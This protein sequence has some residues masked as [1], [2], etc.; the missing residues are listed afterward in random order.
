MLFRRPMKIRI[1][2]FILLSCL[3]LF[4]F[5]TRA[6]NYLHKRITVQVKN[7]P[8][9]GV[10]KI[11][12]QHGGFYFSYNNN[13]I[14][15]DSL[16]TLNINN[17]EVQQAL[18]ALFGKRYQFVERDNYLI[19]QPFLSPQFWYVSGV[20]IDKSTG[21]P[22]SNATVYERQQLI[23]TMTN[24]Q[25]YFRL[26]LKERRPDVNIS[27]SKISYADTFVVLSSAT[28]PE[29]LKLTIAPVAYQLDSVVISG[30]ERTWLGGAFL[31]S[32]QT[33]N[34][35]N[36][37]SFFTKQPFQ[38]S[39]TPGLG[40]HGRMGAQIVNKFSFNVFGGYTAGVNGFELGSLFNIVKKDMKYAQVAGVFNIVGGSV[41]GVQIAGLHNTVLD[42]MSGIQIAGLTNVVSKRVKGIQIAG[43][44]NHAV[45]GDG[46]QVGGLGN[47]NIRHASGLQ[48]AG[49]FNCTQSLNGTQIAGFANV[50]VKTLKGIQIAGLANV[51]AKEVNGLQISAF[52]NV[53]RVLKGVQIGFVNYA[54]TSDG[55]SIGF[56]NIVRR[57][58]HKLS[59]STS[60]LQH[61]NLAY[62]SGNHKLY[63]ILVLGFQVA[64]KEDAYSFGYGLGSDLRLGKKGF[65]FN[66]ELTSL[67]V[68]TG[69]WEQQNLLHRLQLNMKYK[70]GKLCS[71]YMGPAVSILYAKPVG[72]VEGYRSDFVNGYPSFSLGKEV[73][74]WLGW[75]VGVDLF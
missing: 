25:G 19:I 31:S 14:R 22:V 1:I 2:P 41:T 61:V 38:F 54:D 43:L 58:Y 28:Q 3:L 13:I 47:I 17:K 35:L 21:E 56:L 10:L 51:S 66:P 12:E 70:L 42:S 68:Y 9:S 8:V 24:E 11:I 27:V 44:Y 73:T 15:E 55:Y 60:E 46:I 71:V 18:E 23:S 48:V 50:N 59:I 5:S 4:C 72:Y 37:N 52:A 36:L 75:C 49:F 26:Q 34:S 16:V 7:K 63:S 69:D 30:V 65:F 33:M 64:G 53:A 67:Y 62:K 74:G 57:G 29:E 6:Q 20:V 39:L 40:S 45:R 32:K